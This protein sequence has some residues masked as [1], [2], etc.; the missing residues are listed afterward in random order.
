M[1]AGG[2]GDAGGRG[3]WPAG[4][5]RAGRRYTT[6]GGV[7]ALVVSAAPAADGRAPLVRVFALWNEV[8]L[9][10][11]PPGV[12]PLLRLERGAGLVQGPRAEVI[13]GLLVPLLGLAAPLLFVA[14]AGAP[15]ARGVRPKIRL[16]LSLGGSGLLAQ[17][18]YFGAA[19]QDEALRAAL[20]PLGE[21][22]MALP[23]QLR[24]AARSAEVC[25]GAVWQEPVRRLPL[26]FLLAGRREVAIP[27]FAVARALAQD[28]PAQDIADVHSLADCLG[29][30]AVPAS[31]GRRAVLVLRRRG[32][33]VAL[34]VE[35]LLG[36]GAER[37]LPV[38]PMLLGAPWLL[39]VVARDA[40]APVLVIDPLALPALAP[41]VS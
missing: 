19:P 34:R 39:G 35:S 31:G 30:E 24:P 7:R 16:A 1:V 37:V 4:A 32:A 38:G 27:M 41:A 23:P 33:P 6:P 26:V 18:R 11:S 13:A 2:D 3:I 36:H 14:A 21:Q 29:E 17:L 25:L 28:E 20:A 5:V 40:Q 15:A 12:V 22:A 8:L 9:R 10:A